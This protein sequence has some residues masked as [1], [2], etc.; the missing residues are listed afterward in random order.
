MCSSD[1]GISSVMLTGDNE[2]AAKQIADNIGLSSFKA[3]LMPDEKLIFIDQMHREG[4][5]VCMVG[6]GVNDAPALA[7]A[8]CSVAMG[9]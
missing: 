1:L 7:A 4:K 5:K 8:D 9:V 6:D 3:S 2:K